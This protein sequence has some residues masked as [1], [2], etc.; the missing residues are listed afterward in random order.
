MSFLIFCSF[1]VGGIPF[2]MAEILNRFKVETYYVY[3][4]KKSAG[5]DS[6]QFH[7]GNASCKW[8]L[9]N[10]F[11]N[12][13]NDTRKIIQ[14]LKEAKEKYNICHCLAVGIDAYLLKKADISYKYWAYGGDLDQVCFIRASVSNPVLKKRLLI[15][16]LRV[17]H[18]RQ[19]GRKSIRRSDSVMIAP[20]QF[21]ALMK[22]SLNKEM[23]FLPHPLSILEF[24]E[25]Q[26]Q[27]RENRESICKEVEAEK[28][29]FSSTRHVWA[30]PSRKLSDNKG[31]DVIFHAFEK[32]LRLA[33]D[34]HSKLVL[35]K[36][37]DDV[38]HSI[39]LARSLGIEG[40]VEW[41]DQMKREELN[42]YYQ[43][44]SICFGQFGASVINFSL[45]EPLANA[46]ICVSCFKEANSPPPYYKTIPPIFN[47]R[48]PELIAEFMIR[49]L[50]NEKVY[51]G[52]SYDS[53]LWAKE[54]CSE[55]K[56]VESFL[57]LFQEG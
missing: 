11:Q 45:L 48:E 50:R 47:S 26:K 32:Y 44:A 54:N 40:S 53:W 51:N 36:K 3:L 16:P 34:R 2:R 30:G 37:G 41:L 27:R 9:S 14:L 15:H 18:E 8:D 46:S 23:Y 29:F 17:Y 42:K 49:T 12:D 28:Y 33:K 20:Y 10:L 25:L 19:R 7:Y 55:E 35:V 13:L 6:T 1:E 43:G 5:H 57:T 38:E 4:G 56:F 24:S 21:K 22:V 31:N 52:L 39:S